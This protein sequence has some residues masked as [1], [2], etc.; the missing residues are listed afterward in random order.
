MRR[1]RKALEL[2]RVGA[3]SAKETA[4]RL[5]VIDAGLPE[6]ELQVPVEPRRPGGRRADAGYPEY[7]IAIQYDGSSHFTPDRAR[8][9]QRRDNE[10]VAAGWTVLKFNVEDD[11]EGFA[12][13]I[14]QL[15][16]ALLSRG[17]CP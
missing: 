1:A 12:T 8:A 16:V 10:F 4:F 14:Q 9:D 5:A 15:K 11:R 7:K 6:P 13:A 17:W 2:I 3:D